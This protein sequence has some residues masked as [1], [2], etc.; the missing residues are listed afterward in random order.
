MEIKISL[1]TNCKKYDLPY[2][3]PNAVYRACHTLVTKL[4]LNKIEMITIVIM[5][6]LITRIDIT[7]MLIMS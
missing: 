5:M 2:K 7:V 1:Q 4:Y 3:K 6:Q